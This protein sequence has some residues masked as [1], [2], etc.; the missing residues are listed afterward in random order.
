MQGSAI[1]GNLG[2]TPELRHTR[3][4]IP[5]TNITIYENRPPKPDGTRVDSTPH[6]ITIWREMAI[7]AVRSLEK[8]DE[9]V[10]VRGS[11]EPNAYVNREGVQ[12]RDT[13]VNAKVVGLSLRWKDVDR[14][15]ARDSSEYN[16]FD[17]ELPM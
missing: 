17:H 13:V 6:Q 10:V 14:Q 7:H 12:V 8:G 1:V 5:V 2:N 16:E 15:N 9:V 11:E 3:T 4:G